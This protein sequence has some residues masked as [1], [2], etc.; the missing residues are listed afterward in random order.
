L[1]LAF[2][3]LGALMVATT[4]NAR[5][6]GGTVGWQS[7]DLG[8]AQAWQL[9]QGSP[10][11]VVAIVDT[12]VQADHPAL[13]G[14]VLP[15]YDLVNQDADPGDDNGHGTALAGIV[16]SVC[17]SCRILPVKVLAANMTGDWG[18]IA[19]G[20][21]WAADHGAQVINL[22]VGGRRAPDALGAAIAG[23]LAK[24]VI[25]V[26]AAGND[27][28]NETFYPAMYPS[29]VS[30]AGI[31]QNNTRY[32]WSNFGPWVTVAAPGCTTAPSLGGG[33]ETDFC[34]TST[35]APFVAGVAGLARSL[36]P[37]L[38]P[39]QFA[40]ALDASSDPLPDSTTAAAGR[41]DADRLLHLLAAGTRAPVATAAP[42][43]SQS[44]TPG[45][46]I[47]ATNGVWQY[48]TAYALRWQRSRNG[49]NWQNIGTGATYVP[50]R[51]DIGYQLRVVVT[52]T[53]TDRAATVASMPT[54]PVHAAGAHQAGS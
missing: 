33:Y 18:T 41:I 30:V 45:R 29:V 38:T 15:G 42:T 14:R 13:A 4:T 51:R 19:A 32:Q 31:D 35:A 53:N 24:G 16:A 47:S 17:P 25:V 39:A 1:V 26:A 7:A 28:E 11:V 36:D 48:A 49:L 20:V 43:I 10:S 8:L 34:G 40:T 3:L 21:T 54:A 44:P 23:A 46:L 2:L 12:G 50:G 6:A 27:G 9:T 5:A 22:S 52:A 37:A